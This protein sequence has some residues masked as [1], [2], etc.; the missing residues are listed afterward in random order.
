MTKLIMK[1]KKIGSV[2]NASRPGRLKMAKDKGTSTQNEGAKSDGQKFI[3]RDPTSLGA[4][5]NQPKHCH[6]HFAE[7]HQYRTDHHFMPLRL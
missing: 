7:W 6:A 4:N 1:F 2:T 3:K 5:A